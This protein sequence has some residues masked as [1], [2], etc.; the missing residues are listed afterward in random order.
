MPVDCSDDDFGYVSLPA[1]ATNVFGTSDSLKYDDADID[2]DYI[3]IVSPPTPGALPTNMAE[4]F[5]KFATFLGNLQK[6][7]VALSPPFVEE[8]RKY[9]LNLERL[10]DAF[11]GRFVNMPLLG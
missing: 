2:D 8:S 6:N 1:N 11:S 5:T 4:S 7:G 9:H 3:T 10:K